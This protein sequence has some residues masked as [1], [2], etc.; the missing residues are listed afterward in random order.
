M[1]VGKLITRIPSNG[2]RA[3]AR[4]DDTATLSSQ[5]DG[6]DQFVGRRLLMFA[7]QRRASRDAPGTFGKFIRIAGK[8][9]PAKMG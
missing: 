2:W 9:M 1:P 5:G 7:E 4:R 3:A 6:F 8:A